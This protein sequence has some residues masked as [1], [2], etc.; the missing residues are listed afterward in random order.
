VLRRRR[1]RR[2][3]CCPQDRGGATR[4]RAPTWEDLLPH[5]TPSLSSSAG[6]GPAEKEEEEGTEREK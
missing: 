6:E 5:A 1:W 3:H 2:R 4:C